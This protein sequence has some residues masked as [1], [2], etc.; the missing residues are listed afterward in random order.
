R[1]DL[2]DARGAMEDF[3]H[4]L[5]I[6]SNY[7]QAYNNRGIVRISLGERQL[8]IEDFSQAIIIA[9]HYTEAYVNRGYTRYELGSRQKAIEDFNQ[10]LN[11]NPGYAL[12]Y[13]NRGV[14]YRDLGDKEWAKDDF[15]QA[16]R[17]NPHYVEA[18]NNRAIVSYELGDKQGAIEDFNRALNINSNSIEA[19]NI[20][21]NIRYEMGD[22]Q[23][24]MEDF[25]RALSLGSLDLTESGNSWAG[26]TLTIKP[27]SY[28]NLKIFSFEVV[29]KKNPGQ[30]IKRDTSA[31]YFVEDLGDDIT[32]EMVEIPGGTFTINSG[33][34]RG[35]SEEIA[36]H[37]VTIPSFFMGKYEITQEQY[38][39]VTGDNPSYFKGDKRPVE[40]VKWSQ[41]LDFCE[42]LSQITGRIYT[43]PSE[44][45][46][47]YACRG[48]TSTEFY[49]GNT[50]STDLVNYNYNGDHG[51]SLAPQGQ[52]RKQTTEVGS[53]PPNPFGLYD[54]HGN[55][56]EWCLDH[57]RDHYQNI[58][59]DGSPWVGKGIFG[60]FRGH[61][62]RGGSWCD[63]AK[64]CRSGSRNRHFSDKNNLG[65]RVVCSNRNR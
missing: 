12:A 29:S 45:Q 25:N 64:H 55:V 18:Y 4:A 49:F 24:A 39:A 11:I 6:N 56:W 26:L 13:N 48:G 9:Y 2:R 60:V 35:N 53:F 59:K 51:Y 8:A 40:R 5:K 30:I 32:L 23:G 47:E 21:G 65:F 52:Y 7:A 57:W 22:R 58:P 34:N 41:A 50:I 15:S 14:A 10:A 36:E 19:Y 63:S 61:V 62:L 1:Y 38:Q 37:L 43:L 46:W 28:L 27:R 54:M 33:E 3:N 31:I 20:R 42:E 17:V 44:A 16:L